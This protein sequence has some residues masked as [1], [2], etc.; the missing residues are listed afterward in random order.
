M[1]R[2]KLMN[3]GFEVLH[4]LCVIY[5]YTESSKTGTFFIVIG[6]LCYCQQ[7]TKNCFDMKHKINRLHDSSHYRDIV[8][9]VH[10]LLCTLLQIESKNLIS[11]GFCYGQWTFNFQLILLLI[12][13]LI[14]VREIARLTIN[15]FQFRL[16]KDKVKNVKL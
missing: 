15:F 3:N 8:H 12:V 10:P 13:I 2:R 11:N 14:Q 9:V 7:E 1:D 6:K 16:P 5:T 4:Y